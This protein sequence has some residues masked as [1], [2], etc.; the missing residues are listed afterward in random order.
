MEYKDLLWHYYSF[1]YAKYKCLDQAFLKVEDFSNISQGSVKRGLVRPRGFQGKGIKKTSNLRYRKLPIFVNALTQRLP[2]Q[3][4]QACE[5]EQDLSFH[6]SQ[7][8]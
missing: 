1:P 4:S 6:A 3:R 5:S 2:P 7:D 8:K